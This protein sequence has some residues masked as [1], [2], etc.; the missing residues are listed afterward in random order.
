MLML[1]EHQQHLVQS[2]FEVLVENVDVAAQTFYDHL[3]ALD[4]S[5]KSMFQ[6]DSRVQGRKLMQMFLTLVN[7][8]NQPD[9]LMPELSALG[10]R[11]V[12]YGVKPEHFPVV[13]KAL[14]QTVEQALGDDFTPDM[15]NAWQITYDE[16]KQIVIERSYPK[17][18]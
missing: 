8:L 1:T 4:P 6:E 3:F 2:S 9:N 14:L 13:G 7:G 12:T 11:H 16:L 18:V 17:A 10:K 5:L 15:A